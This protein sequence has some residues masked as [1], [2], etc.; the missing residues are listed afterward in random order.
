LTERIAWRERAREVLSGRQ[1]NIVSRSG[2]APSA[3]L[4]P[5]YEDSGDHFV[6]LTRRS[7]DLQHHKG[8]ISFPGGAYDEADGDLRTTALRE[9]GEEIGVRANDVEIL[10]NL[11]DRAT[12]SSNFV[13]TPFV[14][15]IP[16]PYDF[17]VNHREVDVLI[18]ARVA[19][20]LNPQNYRSQTPDSEGN[21]HPWGYF[22]YEEHR[23]TGITALILEQLLDL[24]FRPAWPRG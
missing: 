12:M 5:V 16:Y 11:D 14:G 13:I 15:A 9:A 23:I 1:R 6:V 3:V 18:K 20:L 22:Q 24:V 7:E 4:V 17:K 8:Q 10:G 2:F 21:L 19:E